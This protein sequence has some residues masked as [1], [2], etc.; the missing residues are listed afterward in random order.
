M[1]NYKYSK[2]HEWVKVESDEVDLIGISEH[3]SE[4]LGDIVFV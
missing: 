3:A 4:T 2:E 1:E